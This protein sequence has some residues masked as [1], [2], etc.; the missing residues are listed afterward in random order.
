MNHTPYAV[1]VGARS[2]RLSKAQVEE[3]RQEMS[4][5]IPHIGFT[6]TWIVTLGDVDKTTPLWKASRDFFT[7][8]IDRMLL[9]GH[10]RI[11]IHSAKDLPH[12]IPE[13]LTVVAITHG[14]DPRDSLVM[15]DGVTLDTLPHQAKVGTSSKRREQH[16]LSLRKDLV[17]VDIRG[18][19]DERLSLLQEK[20]VDALVMA[21]AALIRLK[22]THLSRLI[23]DL[24]TEPFQGQI[25]VVAL[26]DDTEMKQL[27]QHIDSRAT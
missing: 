7:R 14:V 20:Q 26:S 22:L 19:I 12:P 27:F 3:V 25:A 1:S 23:L 9:Q 13:D 16:I 17:M 6:P 2:S 15:N 18:T 8:E 21:E 10:F 24:S 4:A 5:Y 11:A